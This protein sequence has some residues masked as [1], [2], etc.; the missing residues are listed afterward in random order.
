MM[1]LAVQY[2]EPAACVVAW[3]ARTL[4]QSTLLICLGLA[5]CGFLRRRS[6]ALRSAVLRGTLLAVLIC[7]LAGGLCGLDLLDVSIPQ[8]SPAASAS[9]SVGESPPASADPGSYSVRVGARVPTEAPDSIQVVLD[10]P[11]SRMRP[12][13]PMLYSLLSVCWIAGAT[14]LLG[15]LGCDCLRA[16][17]RL[18]QAS[19]AS[20]EA[21]AM[22]DEMA[23]RMGLKAPRVAVSPAVASP[24]LIGT[25]RPAILLPQ[26]HP[27]MADAQVSRT[28]WHVRRVA[29]EPAVSARRALCFFQPPIRRLAGEMEQT[30]E[31]A[32]DDIA[33]S[34]VGQRQAYAAGGGRAQRLGCARPRG[35]GSVS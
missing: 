10:V 24:L 9:M 13:L 31:E 30:N 33:V 5:A 7:P 25:F 27:D 3:A 26:A 29:P 34:C 35:W 4:F 21:I 32:C 1:D 14:L 11:H 22:C 20:Q 23:G 19:P 15:R 2:A 8:G 16:R 28:S 18:A 17:R 12:S 6:A